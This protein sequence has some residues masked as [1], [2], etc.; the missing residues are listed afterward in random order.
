VLVFLL[1]GARSGKSSLALRLAGAQPAPVV[2]VATAEARDEEMTA[3]IEQHRAERP[4]QW[5]TVEEPL[6][7][8]DAIAAADPAACVV[9]D[10]LS[11]WVSNLLERMTPEEIETG[12]AAAARLAAGRPGRTIVVSNEA[13]LGLVPLTP[14]GRTWR[15]VNG[16]VNA[17]WADAADRAYFVVAGRALPL[18]DA[19]DLWAGI[20]G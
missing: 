12:A 4:A 9:V 7:L 5:Q 1:G 8:G 2:F 15:D 17:I 20:D 13:G 6:A 14:L 11:I 10:C 3:R 19:T 16:R 18:A